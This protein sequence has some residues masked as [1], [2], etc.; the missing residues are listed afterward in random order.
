MLEA[1]YARS[2][3]SKDAWHPRN[4]R[5]LSPGIDSYLEDALA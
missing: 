1:A 2:S 4:L 3:Q 5:L